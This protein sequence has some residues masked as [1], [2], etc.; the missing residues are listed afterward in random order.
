MIDGTGHGRDERWRVW[1][2][3]K[4]LHSDELTILHFGVIDTPMGAGMDP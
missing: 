3:L 2:L 4:G 1:I